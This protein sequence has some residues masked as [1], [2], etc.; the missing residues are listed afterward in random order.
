V[1]FSWVR[2]FPYHQEFPSDYLSITIPVSS[3]VLYGTSTVLI[4][5]CSLLRSLFPTLPRPPPVSPTNAKDGVTIV[6]HR[7]VEGF[8]IGMRC[9]MGDVSFTLTRPECNVFL[10]LFLL[11]FFFPSLVSM[12]FAMVNGNFPIGYI[13]VI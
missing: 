6:E 8:W 7:T 5:E 11:V 4:L 2:I 3:L 13:I 1:P 9:Q 10:F 12:V